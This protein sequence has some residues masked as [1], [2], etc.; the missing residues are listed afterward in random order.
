LGR[1]R[2]DGGAGN[3]EIRG[4]FGHDTFVFNGGHDEIIDFDAGGGWW[5]WRR[6]GETIEISIE[7]V[8]TFEE[9]E[10]VATQEGRD[11]VLTFS[12]TDSLTLNRTWLA[13]LDESHFEFF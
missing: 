1:D 4:G 11:V 13:K 10:A 2:L 3:D 12:E 6:P 9:L 8:T 7:G 5:W